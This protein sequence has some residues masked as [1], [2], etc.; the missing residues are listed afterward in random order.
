[1]INKNRKKLGLKGPASSESTL[2]GVAF[3]I[4]NA[5]NNIGLGL[6]PILY[7]WINTPAS[8]E[9]YQTTI[10]FLTLVSFLGFCFLGTLCF[11]DYCGDKVLH[12]LETSPSR[13]NSKK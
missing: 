9:S 5:I 8:R 10:L 1:L 13:V 12:N 4:T 3:G 7:G 2:S 11:R 6:W